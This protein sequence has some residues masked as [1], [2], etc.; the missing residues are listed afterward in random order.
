MPTPHIESNLNEIASIVLMPGDPKR[1]KYIADNFL[2]NVNVVNQVRGMNAYT[3]EYQGKRI[4]IFP[5]GMGIPSIGIYSY[6]L[7]KS[8]NVET[9]IRIGTI[10][11]YHSD[12]KLGDIIITSRAYSDSSFAKVQSD[13]KKNYLD[14]D[15]S[16]NQHIIETAEATNTK[17]VKGNIFTSD[18]FYEKKDEWIRRKKQFNV[19]GVEMETFGLLQTAKICNKKATSILT[20]SNS[21]CFEEELSSAEREKNLN[22][23]IE[24]ALK[25]SLK[26]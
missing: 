17:Y 10:G 22:N 1:A 19:L 8:Y 11:A 2:E 16:L 14:S 7:F 12:L 15:N 26:L 21:F 23:M 3:G 6:E 25:T 9:I 18:V 5:S 13:Y 20:V 4:T 24:L